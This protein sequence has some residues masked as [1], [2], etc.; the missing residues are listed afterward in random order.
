MPG[1]E[2][3]TFLF[4]HP[5]SKVPVFKIMKKCEVKNIFCKE[6]LVLIFKQKKS[7]SNFFIDLE[8]KPDT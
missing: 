2:V 8:T 1:C 4:Q 7:F 5:P 3:P 6:I